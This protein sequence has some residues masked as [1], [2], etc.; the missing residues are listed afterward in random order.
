MSPRRVRTFGHH[1]QILDLLEGRRDAN[2][3]PVAYMLPTRKTLRLKSQTA[4]H[5]D[6]MESIPRQHADNRHCR[7]TEPAPVARYRHDRE[8]R[9]VQYPPAAE[10]YACTRQVHDLQREQHGDA[11][12]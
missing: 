6:Q 3:Y 11:P 4:P 12:E 2:F 10:C 1:V 7:V 8:N 5:Q 9:R